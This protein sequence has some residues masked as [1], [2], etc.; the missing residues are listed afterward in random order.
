MFEWVRDTPLVSVNPDLVSCLLHV[1]K[2]VHKKLRQ[3]PTS[4]TFDTIFTDLIFEN[5]VESFTS[6]QNLCYTK[7]DARQSKALKNHFSNIYLE[8][9]V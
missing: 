3:K 8:D 4:K 5:C 2:N 1:Q 7:K 6:C 9:K